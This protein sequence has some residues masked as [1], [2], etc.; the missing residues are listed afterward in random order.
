MQPNSS[1]YPLINYLSLYSSLLAS[2]Q[3][4]GRED[5]I[6]PISNV[7][8]FFYSPKEHKCENILLKIAVA[9]QYCPNILDYILLIQASNQICL[10]YVENEFDMHT[11]N[12]CVLY[13]LCFLTAG[14]YFQGPQDR[15]VVVVVLV[16]L[17]D[18]YENFATNMYF[19][20][21]LYQTWSNL[22]NLDQT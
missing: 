9:C 17:L 11:L 21:K 1:Q 14:I 13:V 20:I 3:S 7:P 2:L 6:N 12:I 16:V 8:H 4:V 19:W 18:N 10:K 15:F 5:Q 22:I